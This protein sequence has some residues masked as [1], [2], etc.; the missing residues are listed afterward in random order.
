MAQKTVLMFYAVLLGVICVVW[1]PRRLDTPG[2][3]RRVTV[4][5]APLWDLQ[6]APKDFVLYKRYDTAITKLA[7]AAI[8]SSKKEQNPQAQASFDQEVQDILEQYPELK[9][10]EKP[11]QLPGDYVDPV[12]YR[13]ATVD[14]GRLSLEV[15]AL[16]ALCGACF[17]LLKN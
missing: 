12:L 15:L 2:E 8:E 1:V 3:S 11:L 7:D 13:Y 9:G 4:Q 6:R 16:T 14:F 10:N 5:Y 17:F